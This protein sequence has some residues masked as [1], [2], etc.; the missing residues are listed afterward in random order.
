MSWYLGI[1]KLGLLLI[2]PRYSSIGNL[3]ISFVSGDGWEF[4]SDNSWGD[5]PRLQRRWG[6]RKLSAS[7]S[8]FIFLVEGS[9]SV[10]SSLELNSLFFSSS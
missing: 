2:F 8:L 9:L 3:D 7:S 4:L 6:T 1:R 5:L 10:L